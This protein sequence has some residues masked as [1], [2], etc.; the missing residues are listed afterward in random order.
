MVVGPWVCLV[1]SAIPIIERPVDYCLWKPLEEIMRDCY[2]SI[3]DGCL[4]F[5]SFMVPPVWDESF[6]EIWGVDLC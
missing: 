3:A 4:Y 2:N 1:E 6:K 5:Q